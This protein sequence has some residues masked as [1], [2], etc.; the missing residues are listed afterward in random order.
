[1]P[2]LGKAFALMLLASIGLSSSTALAQQTTQDIVEQGHSSS[3]PVN[4]SV[5]DLV[6]QAGANWDFLQRRLHRTPLQQSA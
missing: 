3:A 2:S 1:M 6:A 5:E 4:V